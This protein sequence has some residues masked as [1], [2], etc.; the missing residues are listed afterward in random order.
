M[1]IAAEPGSKAQEFDVEERALCSRDANA[2]TSQHNSASYSP[3]SDDSAHEYPPATQSPS[4]VDW[5][6]INEADVQSTLVA[7][8]GDRITMHKSP[9]MADFGNAM[10]GFLGADR[11]GEAAVRLAMA[12]RILRNWQVEGVIKA[13]DML[14]ASDRLQQFINTHY[15]DARICCEWPMTM[16]LE[17]HQRMQGWIDMLLELPNGYIIIDHKSYPGADPLEH[18]KTYA[19]Q[20]NIYQQAVEQATDKPV[21]ATLIHMPIQGVMIEVKTTP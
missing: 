16:V 20:L 13:E 11:A 6:A 1:V 3:I 4:G 10:H 9:D 12:N 2:S 8:I 21:L 19:P 5:G 7:H 14:H 17:N 18:A 15:P